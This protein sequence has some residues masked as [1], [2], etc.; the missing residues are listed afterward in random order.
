MEKKAD[1]VSVGN[2]FWSWKLM[3][4]SNEECAS[5]QNYTSSTSFHLRAAMV[6]TLVFVTLLYLYS[7]SDLGIETVYCGH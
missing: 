3:I 6:Q 1:R 4:V 7:R 2:L 5:F